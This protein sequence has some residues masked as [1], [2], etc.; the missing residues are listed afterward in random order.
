M[1]RLATLNFDGTN[2]AYSYHT[3]GGRYTH[4]S[5]VGVE[6]VDETR[7]EGEVFLKVRVRVLDV[8]EGR[9]PM[10]MNLTVRG[11]ANL[12]RLVS[13]QLAAR[14]GADKPA[15]VWIEEVQMPSLTPDGAISLTE[16]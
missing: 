1:S 13:A 14:Y 15:Y 6:I 16:E 7:V 12:K 5:E 8:A 10:R 3:G 2:I 9:D 4:A 11:Q